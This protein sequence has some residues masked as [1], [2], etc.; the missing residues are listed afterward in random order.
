MNIEEKGHP[1]IYDQLVQEHG[2][3]LTE[4]RKAAEQAQAEAKRALDWSEVRRA[5]KEREDNSFSAFG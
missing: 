5:Q 4:T 1:P 2:D 3:L